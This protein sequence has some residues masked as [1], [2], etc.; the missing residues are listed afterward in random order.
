MCRVARHL[1]TILAALS[2]LACLTLCAV[3]AA[4]RE[5]SLSPVWD[6]R[7]PV[8][9]PRFSVGADR[10]R[11]GLGVIAPD[12]VDPATGYAT[13]P[14]LRPLVDLRYA[15]RDRLGRGLAVAAAS[16]SEAWPLP[17]LRL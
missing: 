6:E 10:R 9:G 15:D 11:L 2:L 1:S 5:G 8:T 7:D 16:P 4:G 3:W 17:H 13:V 14:R 12:A